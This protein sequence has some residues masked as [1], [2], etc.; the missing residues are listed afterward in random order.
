[1]DTV[2]VVHGR[3]QLLHKDHMKYILAGKQRCRHLI[4]GICN[5]DMTRTKFSQA[6]PHRS[7][8]DAN[9]FTYYERFQ[10]IQG[11]MLETGVTMEEFDI[12]PFPINFPELLFNYVPLDAKFYMTIYEEWGIEKQALLQG[13]G[14]DVEVLWQKTPAEKEISGTWIRQQIKDGME[15]R[16]YVP[17]FVYQYIRSHHFES[18]IKQPQILSKFHED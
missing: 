6:A 16:Q 10:M 4:I 1:M 2:G 17:E 9:P 15:W 13:L 8:I 5:P 14:C 7:Q 11:A 18:R 3:F 12:V